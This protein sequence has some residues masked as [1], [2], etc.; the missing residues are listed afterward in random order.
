MN[1]ATLVRRARRAGILSTE[2]AV[3]LALL[4]T[5]S[6]P[7]GY[8]FYHDGRMAR[9]YQHRAVALELVDG[10]MEILAAGA[11]RALPQGRQRYR[12][13]A[14]AATNLPPGEF[15]LTLTQ[16]TA[17]LEWTPLERGRGGRVVREV[18]FR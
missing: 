15:S 5:A 3:A 14:P 1:T 7:I 11:W 2:C 4:A 12:V 13:Q 9:A 8:G 10:E 16:R 18:T 17:R 6:L